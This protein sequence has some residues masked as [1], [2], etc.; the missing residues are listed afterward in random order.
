MG[1]A[2]NGE[3]SGMHNWLR[4]YYLERNETERFDYKGFLV[5]RFVSFVVIITLVIDDV[6]R[7]VTSI[8]KR[9]MAKCKKE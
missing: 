3:V 4:L 2:K 6:A 9:A 1:E 8:L 5:K 7:N